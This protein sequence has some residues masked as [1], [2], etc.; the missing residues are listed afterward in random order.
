MSARMC[1]V[2]GICI[3]FTGCQSPNQAVLSDP[4]LVSRKPVETEAVSSPPVLVA[5]SEP[6]APPHP[7][8]SAF[9]ANNQSKATPGILTSVPR[10]QPK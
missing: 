8:G 1:V 4:L 7:Y 2:L 9:A 10:Q 5:Y 3:A 6:T